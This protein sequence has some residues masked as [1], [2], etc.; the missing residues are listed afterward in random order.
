MAIAVARCAGEPAPE[1][2]VASD[3]SADALR[4]AARNVARH[5]LEDRIELRQGDLYAPL[6]PERGRIDLLLSNP[7]YVAE[8]WRSRLQPEVAREPARALFAGP[9]GLAVIRRLLAEA[10][11]VLAPG[12]HLLVE[13]GYDQAQ[14]ASRLARA[15]GL[16]NV[17]VH[18]DLAG[19]ARVLEGRRGD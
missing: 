13:I 17:R 12:G 14:A 3:V 15:A 7:P 19:R 1:H 8:S 11:A 2:V 6:G 5:G 9:D 16:V 10:P 18:P 4:V